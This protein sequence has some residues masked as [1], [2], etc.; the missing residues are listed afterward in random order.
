M[1][2]PDNR[3]LPQINIRDSPPGSDHNVGKHDASSRW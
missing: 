2:A 1:L 3:V